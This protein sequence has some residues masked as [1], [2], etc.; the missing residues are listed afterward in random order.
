MI[1]FKFNSETLC[2]DFEM[3]EQM[4][5]VEYLYKGDRGTLKVKAREDANNPSGVNVKGGED[6]FPKGSAKGCA[7]NNE[8]SFSGHLKGN[9]LV[10][11]SCMIH[12]T[13]HSSKECNFLR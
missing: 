7:G 8:T 10:T 12:G 11:P 4:E 3:F 1:K 9:K 13:R 5:V 2:L 6:N